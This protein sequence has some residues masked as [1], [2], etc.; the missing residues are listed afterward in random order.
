VN[1]RITDHSSKNT[2]HDRMHCGMPSFAG[3]LFGEV[4]KAVPNTAGIGACCTFTSRIG[5]P[6]YLHRCKA[7]VHY[8]W[9]LKPYQYGVGIKESS[10][11]GLGRPLCRSLM[12][13]SIRRTTLAVSLLRVR[14]TALL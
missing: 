13:G 11:V 10:A 12:L 14:F 5:R 6:R 2:H 9:W 8:A 4:P 3:S 1:L 7:R